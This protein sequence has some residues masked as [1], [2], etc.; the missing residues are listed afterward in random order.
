M[1]GPAGLVDDSA[2]QVF[3][4]AFFARST[5]K[6]GDRGYRFTLIEAGHQ[7]QNLSLIATAMG[8]GCIHVGGYQDHLIDRLLGLDGINASTIYMAF[9]GHDDD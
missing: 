6:Y 4:V 9:L 2:V 7:A 8:L 5:F 3:Q 1:S